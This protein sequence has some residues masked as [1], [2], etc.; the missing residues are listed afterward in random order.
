MI[1]NPEAAG[2]I[3][4]ARAA[5]KYRAASE[6]GSPLSEVPALRPTQERKDEARRMVA[7]P[8]PELRNSGIWWLSFCS[9]FE[10]TFPELGDR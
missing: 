6:A 8:D 10:K 7:S 1:D 2:E 5:Q 9:A 3:A 4:G